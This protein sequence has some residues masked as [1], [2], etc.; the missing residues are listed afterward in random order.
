[1]YVL[2]YQVWLTYLPLINWTAS[3]QLSVTFM[4]EEH[5]DNTYTYIFLYMSAQERYS[6]QSSAIVYTLYIFLNAILTF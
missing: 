5:L 1:M 2:S 4:H 3:G 6:D